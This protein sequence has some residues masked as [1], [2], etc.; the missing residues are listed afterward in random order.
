LLLP[1]VSLAL[2]GRVAFVS[3]PT[4]A[5]DFMSVYVCNVSLFVGLIHLQTQ[6]RV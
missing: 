2:H 6:K 4:H 1:Q 3:P 5:F